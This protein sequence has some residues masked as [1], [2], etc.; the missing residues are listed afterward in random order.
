[1]LSHGL[2]P[3]AQERCVGENRLK[4]MAVGAKVS[5]KAMKRGGHGSL[6]NGWKGVHIE[7]AGRCWIA[8][9]GGDKGEEATVAAGRMDGVHLEVSG[10]GVMARGVRKVVDHMRGGVVVR[11]IG[12]GGLAL[13]F[14]VALVDERSAAHISKFAFVHQTV[15]GVARGEICVG[16]SLVEHLQCV[17]D[18][19]RF[20]I[21]LCKVSNKEV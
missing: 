10:F 17:G 4:F 14:L 16:R 20:S 19:F 3:S 8:I 21:C 12:G 5:A 7:A 18:T 1:M 9:V 2:S 11:D 15:D 13:V 6:K